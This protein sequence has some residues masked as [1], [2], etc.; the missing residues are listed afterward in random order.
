MILLHF[1]RYRSAGISYRVQ[2]CPALF[3]GG[4]LGLGAV[5]GWVQVLRVTV[6]R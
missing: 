2:G 4:C 6:Y 3:G 5:Q 1:R